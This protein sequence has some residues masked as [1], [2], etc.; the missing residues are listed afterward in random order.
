MAQK[1]VWIGKTKVPQKFL[2]DLDDLD[3]SDYVEIFTVNKSGSLRKL[4]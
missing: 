1:S 2:N 4:D 3:I